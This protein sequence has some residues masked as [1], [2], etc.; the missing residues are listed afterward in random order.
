MSFTQPQLEAVSSRSGQTL[1]SA[2]AGSG[3]T[4]VLTKRIEA[5]VRGADMEH[6]AEDDGT[7]V[8]VDQME[9]IRGMLVMTF[10]RAAAGEMRGRIVAALTKAAQ[11]Q[12]ELGND[13]AARVLHEQAEAAAG[14]DIS[15]VHSFCTRVIAENYELAD[16]SAG[17]GIL[18]QEQADQLMEAA[19]RELFDEHY[20]AEDQD[21]VRLLRKFTLKGRDEELIAIVLKIYKQMMGTADWE[22]WLDRPF[23]PERPAEMMQRWEQ[24]RIEELEHAIDALGRAEQMTRR[25]A[26]EAADKALLKKADQDVKLL[27]KF[28][29][30][31]DKA[32]VDGADA[33]VPDLGTVRYPRTKGMSGLAGSAYSMREESRAALKIFRSDE[34]AGA[35]RSLALAEAHEDMHILTS[36]VREFAARYADKKRQLNK[37]DYSD[38]EHKALQVLRALREEGKGYDKRYHHVFVDEYQD[39]NNVQESILRELTGDNQVFMVG[40]LKQSIYGFRFADPSIFRSKDLSFAERRDAPEQCIHMNH[41]FRSAPAVIDAVNDVMGCLMR[42]SLG[43]V[44]YGE[45]EQLIYGRTDGMPGHAQILVADAASGS[46]NEDGNPRSEMEAEMIAS[47][48]AELAAQGRSFGDIVILLRSRSDRV[49]ALERSLEMRG[50]PYAA[51]IDSSRT[52][53]EL[54]IYLN[55]LELVVNERR[56]VPLL[57]VM[58]SYMFGFSEADFARIVNWD[59]RDEHHSGQAFFL[60]LNRYREQYKKGFADEEDRELGKRIED[61]FAQLA[62]LRVRGTDMSLARFAEEAGQ[63]FDFASYLLTRPSGASRKKAYDTLLQM[64]AE[65]QEIYG[66]SLFRV[67]QAV[68]KIRTA[69]SIEA[70]SASL[71]TDAV[72]IM[73]IHRSKGLEA[74][75]VFLAGMDRKF[76]KA[77]MTADFLLSDAYGV[78]AKYVDD[79]AHIKQDTVETAVVRRYLTE[80]Q[81]SEELRM[82]YVAMTRARDE[83]Y[84]CGAAA[85]EPGSENAWRALV[86]R[87]EYAGS[88]LDWVMAAYYEML[89]KGQASESMYAGSFWR[90][91]DIVGP[92]PE[93]HPVQPEDED[94]EDVTAFVKEAEAG[95]RTDFY[96]LE[97]RSRV[98]A[99]LGVSKRIA[100]D[101]K[102]SSTAETKDGE[103]RAPYDKYALRPVFPEASD[104][105]MTGAERGTLLHR[106]LQYAVRTGSEPA[107]TVQQMLERR[108]VS[109]AEANELKASIGALQSFFDSPLYARV[110]KADKVLTEQAFE[111][112]VPADADGYSNVSWRLA[113]KIDLAFLEN[114]RWVLVDYKSDRFAEEAELAERYAQQIMY[115]KEALEKITGK[116]V[117]ESY[118]YSLEKR[119]AIPVGSKAAASGTI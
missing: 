62:E 81:L 73:T 10:T 111:L 34:F 11:A 3:K 90:R 57:S 40:D 49:G 12:A 94:V 33:A 74:P 36:L 92:A 46:L 45:R 41:N 5:L 44:A 30:V 9:D 95:G 84:L 106:A 31:L 51:E 4:H 108:L 55:L 115:Y 35:D 25:A 80:S 67:L 32:R 86:G 21:I 101:R 91:G 14:A 37:V 103:I 82:L 112:L 72:R 53:T 47:R 100:A 107:K 64:I 98:Q 77:S 29:A 27:A 71:D 76:N 89:E 109:P 18:S 78:S 96:G 102:D 15:T 22:E 110:L 68:R 43:G 114:G 119:K 88:M 16:V 20:E 85:D 54:D 61:F 83:L 65:Q 39:T 116:K 58:R 17:F 52:F 117:A 7:Q 63:K 24:I 19:A 38:L 99:K 93:V 42:E 59:E 26:M 97:K 75:V 66:N 56:D 87:Y 70:Q 104:G 79:A 69:G 48:I 1:V 23:A 13:A 50:I 113:G 105:S 60:R 118:L 2:A 28:S 8:N 6:F